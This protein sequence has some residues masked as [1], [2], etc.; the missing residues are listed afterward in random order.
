MHFSEENVDVVLEFSFQLVQ[1]YFSVHRTWDVYHSLKSKT[2]T[3]RSEAIET[4]IHSKQNLVI[5]KRSNIEFCYLRY[6]RDL[7]TNI[8][9]LRKITT[10]VK[11]VPEFR[12]FVEPLICILSLNKYHSS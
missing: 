12:D 9:K 4:D 3:S 5:K 6:H 7:K 1:S 8:D 2:T 11:D 10:K